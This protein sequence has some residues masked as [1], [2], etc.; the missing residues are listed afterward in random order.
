MRSSEHLDPF[1][2]K[3]GCDKFM[4]QPTNFRTFLRHPL[5]QAVL[6]LLVAFVIFR[7]GIRPATPSSVLV[8]YM[9]IVMAAVILYVSS[10]EHSWRK[11]Q[12]PFL[13]L[14]LG[15]GEWIT[16]LRWT[17]AGLLPLL[18]G[19]HAY[20]VVTSA[21]EAPAELRQVHP[22]PPF[23]TRFRGQTVDIQGLE[24][25]FWKGSQEVPDP[26]LV[27]EG[28]EI[29]VTNCV[30]CHGDTLHGDG[31]FAQGLNPVPADFTDAATI[32][33]LQQSYVFWRIAKGGRGLPVESAPWNSAMPAWEEDLTQDEIWKVIIYLYEGAGPNVNPRIWE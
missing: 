25:P 30:F 2:V 20:T 7:F 17:I 24:N 27:A 11:F 1:F 6:V 29:Y 3:E 26:A 4:H 28:R 9:S 19:L 21:A 23:S 13:T 10:S 14:L 16:R 18:V 32:T 8:L 31:L 15:R 22:A 12:D 5:V 33:Q